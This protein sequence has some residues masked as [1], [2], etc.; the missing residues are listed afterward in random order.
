LSK[1]TQN[2]QTN[3]GWFVKTRIEMKA[4]CVDTASVHHVAAAAAPT[5]KAQ[6]QQRL[7][8][9]PPPTPPPAT[10]FVQSTRFL[11]GPMVW[12]VGVSFVL[13][14]HATVL[15]QHLEDNAAFATGCVL[16]A[17]VSL[18]S[19]T[20]FW[21]DLVKYF[22]ET[23]LR[24]AVVAVSDRSLDDVLRVLCDPGQ[25]AACLSAVIA[26]PVTLYALPTT[27]EQRVQVLRS[28]GL[29]PRGDE[30]DDDATAVLTRAGGWKLL[31]PEKMQQLLRTILQEEHEPV[32]LPSPREA[33]TDPG[34]SA[35]SEGSNEDEQ[36]DYYPP[37]SISPVYRTTS[38]TPPTFH[39]Q[40]EEEQEQQKDEE[41]APGLELSDLISKIV[42]NLAK[43]KLESLTATLSEHQTPAA[44]T[45]LAATTLLV[46]QLRYSSTARTAVKALLHLMVTAG[47][48]TALAGSLAALL[49]PHLNKK[50]NYATSNQTWSASMLSMM[51]SASA[52]SIPRSF[53]LPATMSCQLKKYG[54]GMLAAL[55]LF[56]FQYRHRHRLHNGR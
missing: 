36:E 2:K 14:L 56:Y 48:S 39:D 49:A 47:G 27:P 20:L 41:D 46:A 35:S 7:P 40:E 54:K 23:M 3:F 34:S 5:T 1:Q 15:S 52:A 42:W 8:P 53:A 45:A 38:H 33:E 19:C 11:R 17:T 29:L 4:C 43:T 10:G 26:V 12:S 51:W 9:P 18:Y 37:Y 25:L 16:F 55:V 24:P 50:T 21:T 44:V 13:V 6:D 22:V 32:L 31:L 30:D 28:A